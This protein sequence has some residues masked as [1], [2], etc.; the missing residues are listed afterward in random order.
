M[1]RFIDYRVRTAQPQD[2]LLLAPRLREI[3]QRETRA[4]SGLE[5][6][7]ALKVSLSR[8]SAAWTAKTTE[9]E[10]ILMWGVGRVG[11]LLGFVGAPWMLASDILERPEVG[12]EFIR[13][14]RPY[15]RVLELGFRRLVNRV[16]AENRLAIRWLRWLGFSFAEKPER[17]GGE[18]FYIF[19][20][21]CVC[22][23]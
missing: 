5:P 1:K 17:L 20:K 2:A 10:V 9:G 15:A 13:L 3:D 16:H 8:S 19:W 23:S 14:S 21:D 22:A 18:E 11:G 6:A 4:M 12:R 7:E